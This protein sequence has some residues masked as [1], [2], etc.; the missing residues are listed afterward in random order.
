MDDEQ[1]QPDDLA[2]L[3]ERTRS[4]LNSE[5]ETREAIPLFHSKNEALQRHAE[6]A[7]K[8]RPGVKRIITGYARHHSLKPLSGL[9][10][11]HMRADQIW[12]NAPL[13]GRFFLA[14]V[15]SNSPVYNASINIVVADDQGALPVSIYQA[16]DDL[17]FFPG[18]LIGILCSFQAYPSDGRSSYQRASRQTP[19]RVFTFHSRRFA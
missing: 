19:P 12:A 7:G 15:V 10:P 14:R 17:N 16:E 5:D 1:R 3:I 13:A 4:L 18:A 2:D 11:I 9:R 8:G 6:L